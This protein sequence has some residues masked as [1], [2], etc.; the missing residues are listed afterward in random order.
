MLADTGYMAWLSNQTW[1][2]EHKLYKVIVV[3]QNGKQDTPTPEHNKIQNLFLDMNFVRK[4]YDY[5]NGK[6][7]YQ[8]YISWLGQLKKEVKDLNESKTSLLTEMDKKIDDISEKIRMEAKANT[9]KLI[10]MGYKYYRKKL[11]EYLKNSKS[12]YR[13]R[14]SS[15]RNEIEENLAAFSTTKFTP[16]EVESLINFK[17][18]TNKWTSYYFLDS[19]CDMYKLLKIK[20]EVLEEERANDKEIKDL[21]S[22]IDGISNKIKYV[23]EGISTKEIKFDIRFEEKGIDV[24]IKSGGYLR[25][26][27]GIE[28]KPILG[29]DY[30]CVLRKM[31]LLQG[32][33]NLPYP[34]ILLV[35]KFSSEGATRSQLGSIF[36]QEGITVIFLAD[37]MKYS[38]NTEKKQ[39]QYFIDST[40]S[41]EGFISKIKEKWGGNI[42]DEILDIEVKSEAL[43]RFGYQ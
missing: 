31:K 28:I 36:K 3:E 18:E 8:Y 19:I 16:K 14:N 40:K 17:Y 21:N 22:S 35:D 33:P 34:N 38:N 1:W 20:D 11:D 27:Y 37:L 10:E 6:D 24:Y 12:D 42:T 2:K 13:Y 23:E 29:D 4:F 43:S 30:P 39:L 15:A 41:D 32:R 25:Q 26:G 9:S 5:I 7:M